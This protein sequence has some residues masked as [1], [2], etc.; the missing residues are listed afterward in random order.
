MGD[1]RHTQLF[2]QQVKQDILPDKAELYQAASQF[3]AEND[4]ALQGLVKLV[5]RDYPFIDQQLAKFQRHNDL[6]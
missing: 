2:A 5:L 6:P 4:M 3:D 1:R